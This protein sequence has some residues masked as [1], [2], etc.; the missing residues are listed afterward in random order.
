MENGQRRT[1][2]T[3]NKHCKRSRPLCTG[4]KKTVQRS[5]ISWHAR[6]QTLETV[7]S[8]SGAPVGQQTVQTVE[9]TVHRRST[10]GATVANLMARRFV[11][12]RNGSF[13]QRSAPSVNKR[14]KAVEV[15]L[16]RRS[17]NGANLM[18]ARLQTLETVVSASG[19]PRRLTNG[20][21]RSRSLVHRRSTN[22]AKR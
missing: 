20:T 14:Y 16:Q 8:V 15:A 10:N 9:V 1:A 4:G 12:P 7:V 22:G 11:N 18:A 6:L 5:R 19:T 13:L 3:V 17:T 21:K 2:P